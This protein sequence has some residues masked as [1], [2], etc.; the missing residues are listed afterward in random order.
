[1]QRDVNYQRGAFNIMNDNSTGMPEIVGILAT[2]GEASNSRCATHRTFRYNLWRF[3][4]YPSL[5][6]QSSVE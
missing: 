6:E 1:M 2:V 3:L 4:Q 5:T